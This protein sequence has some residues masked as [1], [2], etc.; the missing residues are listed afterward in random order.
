FL[1]EEHHSSPG[2]NNEAGTGLGLILCKEFITRHD[3]NIWV[4]SAIDEGSIFH[5][6]IPLREEEDSILK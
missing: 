2:T 6:S 1:V 4:E 5:F 3:G